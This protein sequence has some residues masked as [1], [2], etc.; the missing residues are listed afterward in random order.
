M[1]TVRS[2]VWVE[3]FTTYGR[4]LFRI[5]SNSLSFLESSPH[6]LHILWTAGNGPDPRAGRTA[7]SPACGSSASSRERCSQL[8]LLRWFRDVHSFTKSPLFAR[9]AAPRRS[10]RLASHVRPIQPH[11]LAAITRTTGGP[12]WLDEP[13][14][15][16]VRHVFVCY[17]RPTRCPRRGA[18]PPGCSG[19]SAVESRRHCAKESQERTCALCPSPAR[20][21][22]AQVI[23]RHRSLGHN[24]S[25][26]PFGQNTTSCVL[27]SLSWCR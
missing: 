27:A 14:L 9:A 19:M 22:T 17:V 24:M 1:G 10:R 15:S 16:P 2:R 21:S 3:G 7:L 12:M 5:S 18:T 8:H 6:V 25:C 26:P 20:W 11:Q 23:L 4:K 13:A